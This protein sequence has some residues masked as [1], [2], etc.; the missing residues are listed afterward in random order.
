VRQHPDDDAARA[1]LDSHLQDLGYGLLLKRYTDKVTDAT[2]EQI[3]KAAWDT[4]PNVLPLFWSFRLMV[5]LGFFFIGYFALAFW[6]SAKRRL[7]HYR[8][9]LRLAVLPLPLPWISSELGW[10]VAE[11]GRQPWTIDGILPT[12]LSASS[13]TG[14]SVLISLA[15]FVLFYSALAVIELFLMIKYIRLGPEDGMGAAGAKPFVVTT[16][17]LAPG[18]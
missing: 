15:G 3:E 10:F 11:H 16:G 2:P 1:A 14:N 13:V 9:F 6:L 12:F 17:K 4:V 5:M 18:E 7:D 8:W